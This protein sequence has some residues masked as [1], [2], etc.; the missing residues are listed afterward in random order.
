MDAELAILTPV[1]RRVEPGMQIG[2]YEVLL[3]VARGGMASVWAARQNGAR[4]F[5]RLVALKTVLP[6]LAEPEFEAMF[7]DEARVAARIHHPNVCDIF[8]LIEDSGILALSMEW[9]DGDTLNS[10]IDA[11]GQQPVLDARIGAHIVAQVACG[12]HAAHVLCDESGAAMQLVHRDVSPQN[13]LISRDGHVK[14]TDFGIAKALGGTREA[15]AVGQIKGKLSYMSPE[16]AEG[17]AL[18]H[19]SDIFSL[20]VVL[21]QATVG[22]HPFRR[23]NESRQQLLLRLLLDPIAPPSLLLPGYPAELEAIVLRALDRDPAQRFA[24][25]DEMR[26]QLQEWLVRTGPLVTEHHIAQVLAQRVGPA[27]A[28]RSERIQRS[29]RG[30]RQLLD[31]GTG[32]RSRA[33]SGLA[34]SLEVAEPARASPAAAPAGKAPEVSAISVVAQTGSVVRPDLTFV[35][36]MS[37]VGDPA[38]VALRSRTRRLVIGLGAAGVAILGAL[39]VAGSPVSL[40]TLFGR[41]EPQLAPTAAA[42][43]SAA[44]PIAAVPIA[45]VSSA[46][47]SATPGRPAPPRAAASASAN[48]KPESKKR[49]RPEPLP[50]RSTKSINA[51]L[52]KSASPE[53]TKAPA[54]SASRAPS[55][56]PPAPRIGPLEDEL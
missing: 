27:M 25:A 4:G 15:T 34:A 21:Y 51:A 24:T 7:V 43:P 41:G 35:P 32:T 23:D 47:V 36:T 6:E 9:I 49:T 18:D 45:A 55:R 28:K 5:T 42:M 53:A 50:A 17:G 20:G 8:E 19:R 14:V 26:R 11:R 12:L 33:A 3:C 2:T 48:S 22:T 56:A 29:L 13:I 46:A 30:S 44:D 38:R 1:P 10:V 37:G 52:G 16:Q 54:P 39:F 40:A 31:T